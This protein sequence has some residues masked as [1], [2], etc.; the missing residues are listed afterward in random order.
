MESID[1]VLVSR[2]YITFHK[3]TI[4]QGIFGIFLELLL[5][6]LHFLLHVLTQGRPLSS[7]HIPSGSVYFLVPNS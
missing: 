2:G 5:E 1:E 3:A 7:V 6:S 4:A